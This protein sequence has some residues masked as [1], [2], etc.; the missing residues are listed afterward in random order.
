MPN[1]YAR[2]ILWGKMVLELG[3][4]CTAKNER[5]G[6]IADINFKTK[7]SP[8]AQHL[9]TE[10]AKRSLTRAQGYFSG[11]YNSIAGKVKSSSQEIGEVCGKWSS[12]M[13]YKDS[14]TGKK[15]VLF[16]AQ[17]GGA[18]IAPKWV[19][20]EAEQDPHESRR[21]WARLTQAIGAKDMDAATEAKGAVEESQREERR[22]REESGEAHVPRFFQQREG[23]WV[24]TFECVR[25]RFSL[26]LCC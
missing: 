7:V 10:M 4:S 25:S 26:G 13:E 23:R 15:R 3:D 21:L 9:T 24:P 22:R 16:D 6:Y 12:V 19:A 2:G 14:K 18:Q 5:N 8:R 20:P 17:A 1:M 11:A